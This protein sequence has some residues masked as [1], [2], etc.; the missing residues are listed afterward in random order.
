MSIAAALRA[1]ELRADV[2][3]VLVA[4]R[5]APA[6]VGAPLHAL[7]AGPRGDARVAADSERMW[8]L[9]E[10]WMA[11]WR[12]HAAGGAA[13]GLGGGAGA[14]PSEAPA[15]RVGGVGDAPARRRKV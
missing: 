1:G 6:R 10:G 14:V 9:C 4:G 2:K 15:R 13:E 7:A 5:L 11:A 3:Y 8:A 12:A